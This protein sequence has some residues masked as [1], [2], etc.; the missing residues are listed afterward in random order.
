MVKSSEILS[1]FLCLVIGSRLYIHSER[2]PI[3]MS[4]VKMKTKIEGKIPLIY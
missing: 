4:R 2:E 1:F 3:N